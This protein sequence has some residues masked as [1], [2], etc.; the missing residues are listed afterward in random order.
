M[1]A[2]LF[3][4][5]RKIESGKLT[6]PS[7]RKLAAKNSKLMRATVMQYIVTREEFEYYGKEVFKMLGDG[8]LKIKFHNV[9]PLKDVAQCHTVSGD[10]LPRLLVLVSPA[11]PASPGYTG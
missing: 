9:Y 4:T 8:A 6:S 11:N 3:E 2:L 7:C 5:P 1:S 10:P